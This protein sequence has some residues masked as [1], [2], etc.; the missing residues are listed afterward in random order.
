M[1]ASSL[2]EKS[3]AD[4]KSELVELRKEAF[5]LRMQ[6]ATDQLQK[7]HQIKEVRRNIARVNT[8]LTEKE[9]AEKVGDK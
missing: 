1:Q 5:N 6:K 7:T 2:R 9:R 3:V 8:V 4:L